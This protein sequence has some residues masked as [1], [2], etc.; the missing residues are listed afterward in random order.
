MKIIR[1]IFLLVCLLSVLPGCTNIKSYRD[2]IEENPVFHLKNY[3]AFDPHQP[4]VNR[5]VPAPDFVLSYLKKFDGVDTY[6]VYT[7]SEVEVT[8]CA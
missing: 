4:L 7:P 8:M 3:P 2:I 6:E 1:K 5:I